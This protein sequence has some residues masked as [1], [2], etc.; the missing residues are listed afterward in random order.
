TKDYVFGGLMIAAGLFFLGNNLNLL[1][2]FLE[3]NFFAFLLIVVGVFII[4]QKKSFYHSTEGVQSDNYIRINAIF[5]GNERVIE[6]KEFDGGDCTAIFGSIDIDFRRAELKPD[7][8]PVY[9]NIIFGGVTLYVPDDWN[10]IFES[11]TVFGSN[12]DSRKFKSEMV[13]DANKNLV[14]KG[15][16]IFGGIEIKS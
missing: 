6:S 12:E 10:V 9:L 3:D 4:S 14:V 11:T 1:P 16:C 5:G 8:Q 7:S 2:Y 13:K 15:L